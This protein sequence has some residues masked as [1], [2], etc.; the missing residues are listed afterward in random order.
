M[1]CIIWFITCFI[2]LII[3]SSI[4]PPLIL[5]LTVSSAVFSPLVAVNVPSTVTPP[6]ISSGTVNV[7]SKVLGYG[8]SVVPSSYVFVTVSTVTWTLI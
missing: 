6:G 1:A 7:C 3:F 2:K 4:L 5:I 8:G